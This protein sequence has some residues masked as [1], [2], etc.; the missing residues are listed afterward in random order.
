MSTLEDLRRGDV[1]ALDA[2][3]AC[4]DALRQV[5]AETSAVAAFEDERAL[6]DAQR[7]DAAFA[8]RGSVGPLHG[9]PVTVKDWIDVEGFV[10]AGDGGRA[11]GRADG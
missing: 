3:T 9:L 8:A 6:A 10:C 1:S 7:L 5:D 2:V 4:I 11:P